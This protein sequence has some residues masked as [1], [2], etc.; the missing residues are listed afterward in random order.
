MSQRGILFSCYW[1]EMYRVNMK[2]QEHV[3]STI[4]GVST[5]GFVTTEEGDVAAW[6]GQERSWE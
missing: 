3:L 4:G 1:I 2:L 6:A 5:N